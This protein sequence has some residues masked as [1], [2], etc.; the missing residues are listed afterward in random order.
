LERIE[1]VLRVRNRLITVFGGTGFIGR[2]LVRRLAARG[3]RVLVI[4]RNPSRGYHLQPMGRVGQI[5][6]ER[7]DLGS[8]QALGRALAGAGGVVNL[9]GILYETRRQRFAEVQG[10]L[11]GRI[12]KVA[13]DAGI[14]RMVQLSAIGAD[15]ASKSAYARSKAEGERRVR[16]ALASATIVRPSI[17][18]GPEDGFF[19]RFAEMARWLPALPLIGGGETRFQPV[20]VGDVADAIVAG[21]ERPDTAGQTYEVG[22]PQVYSFAELMRYMLDVLD[23]RRLLVPLSFGMAELQARF[24]ELL[25]VPPLTRDQVE[26]L[27]SDNVVAEGAKGLADLAIAPTPIE[28]IVP[29]YLM[30]YRA[31]AARFAGG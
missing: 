14:E 27:K 3:A 11:P 5:L 30:R 18:I 16:E 31:S 15:A 10:A 7:V 8:E 23:R 19:N 2:H 13:A 17:V 4:S 21:L 24:L 22:G 26:L 20:Y 25:P 29:E 6:V 1:R 12:A 9:I 28:L